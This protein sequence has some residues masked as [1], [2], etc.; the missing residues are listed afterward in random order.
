MTVGCPPVDESIFL[1]FRVRLRSIHTVRI[2]T[3][4]QSR[5]VK[6]PVLEHRLSRAAWSQLV[7]IF[8][9]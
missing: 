4:L 6:S 1:T 9:T 7:E 5:A 2:R 8:R 3:F